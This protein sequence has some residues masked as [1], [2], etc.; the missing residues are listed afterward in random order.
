M[1]VENGQVNRP[2]IKFLHS[3]EEL[4]VEFKRSRTTPELMSQ[5]I[6]EKE[7]LDLFETGGAKSADL[8]F[9]EMQELCAEDTGCI[10]PPRFAE[11]LKLNQLQWTAVFSGN[12]LSIVFLGGLERHPRTFDEAT[13]IV[14]IS[15]YIDS[16]SLP[17]KYSSSQFD[18]TV[19][20]S[21]FRVVGVSRR[22]NRL[23]TAV[24]DIQ[25]CFLKR[26]QIGLDEIDFQRLIRIYGRDNFYN[27]PQSS[28]PL[29]SPTDEL[30]N[31]RIITSSMIDSA[32]NTHRLPYM[33]NGKV[34]L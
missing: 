17:D 6:K 22:F 8:T 9:D 27:V 15:H 26:A 21:G 10:L 14:A 13:G 33:L 25:D 20:P 2:D 3:G 19:F 23:T 5:F 4:P 16:H 34:K 31:N 7:L 18:D 32:Q 1:A 30:K 24:Y 12:S 28:N 29:V 11:D